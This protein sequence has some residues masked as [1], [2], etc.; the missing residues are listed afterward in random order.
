M[1]AVGTKGGGSVLAMRVQEDPGE[2]TFKGAS[3]TLAGGSVGWSAIPCTKR[4]WVPFLVRARF[5]VVGSIQGQGA[6]EKQPIHVSV[7]LFKIN[8]HILG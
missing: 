4:L 3:S 6:Y 1:R 8:K 7:S 5:Q 2:C